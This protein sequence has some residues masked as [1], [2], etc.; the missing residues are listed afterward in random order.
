VRGR[1]LKRREK[2]EDGRQVE[3]RGCKRRKKGWKGKTKRQ[4]K[5]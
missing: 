2:Y 1:C 3:K 4:I 5:R